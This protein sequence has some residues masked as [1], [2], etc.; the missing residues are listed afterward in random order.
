MVPT[1]AAACAAL[2]DGG[3]P[4]GLILISK[5]PSN[6]SKHIQINFTSGRTEIR[7]THVYKVI[8]GPFPGENII[9]VHGIGHTRQSFMNAI[10]LSQNQF[11]NSKVEPTSR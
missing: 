1:A 5:H 9:G 4:A 7:V 2:G 3:S 11:K 10:E 8:P 6:N